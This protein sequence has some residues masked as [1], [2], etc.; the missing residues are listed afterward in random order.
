[1]ILLPFIIAVMGLV[2]YGLCTGKVAVI[3]WSMFNSG[4]FI[5]LLCLCVGIQT[6]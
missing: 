1:M 4:L 5:L 3:G 2:V 6:S